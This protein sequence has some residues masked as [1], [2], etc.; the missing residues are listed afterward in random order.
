MWEE[1][2][3]CGGACACTK[4]GGV[5]TCGTGV[6]N[7]KTSCC[8]KKKCCGGSWL[9]ILWAVLALLA[10]FWFGMHMW[11]RKSFHHMRW[12]YSMGSQH[13]ECMRSKAK[14]MWKGDKEI[15][16]PV[17]VDDSDIPLLDEIEDAWDDVLIE[18][19]PVIDEVIDLLDGEEVE[20]V[21]IEE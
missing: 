9:R 21:V 18:D 17:V 14:H 7:T 19:L 4:E 20:G 2:T 12:G 11:M 5:C 16:V 13:K 1:K 3:C 15:I 8:T 6:C 10:M